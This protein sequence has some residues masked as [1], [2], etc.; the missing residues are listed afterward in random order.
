MTCEFSSNKVA[1]LV[2]SALLDDLRRE[3]FY[4]QAMNLDDG[5]CQARKDD[6]SLSIRK[7]KNIV[8]I[9][10]AKADMQFI[11]T[12][13]YEVIVELYESILK[14]KETSDPEVMKKEL[15]DEDGRI[16]QKLLARI[17]PEC[18]SL[19]LKGATMEEIIT[20][21]VDILNDRG[22]ILDRD[23]VIHDVLDREKSMSTGM[24][25]GIC[26]PHAKT[27]GVGDLVV[28]VGVKKEGIDWNSLDEIKSQLFILMV[29]PKKVTGPH[30]QF[31]A[32]IASVLMDE[33]T[34]EAV[35]KAD[36]PEKVAELLVRK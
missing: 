18:I 2:I 7:I 34:R 9:V 20:E 35:I 1:D 19:D 11:K 14:L 24:E 26:L 28:A 12:A 31:L 17:N 5:L 4:V 29:S 21:L 25:Y 15:L 10:T 33:A 30:I 32:A 22:L 27:D 6:I 3:G 13:I 8:T 16:S 23:I 36:T